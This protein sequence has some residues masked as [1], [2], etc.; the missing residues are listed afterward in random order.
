MAYK[1]ILKDDINEKINELEYVFDD[2]MSIKEIFAALI[3]RYCH[4]V[5]RFDQFNKLLG[6]GYE[7]RYW[8]TKGIEREA[9]KRAC[10]EAI[11][12]PTEEKF[13]EEGLEGKKFIDL[14][15]DYVIRNSKDCNTPCENIVREIIL[16]KVIYFY[17]DVITGLYSS[18]SDEIKNA[19]V[20]FKREVKDFMAYVF[21]ED[22]FCDME[23]TDDVKAEIIKFAEVLKD[24]R[25]EFI[26][27]YLLEETSSLLYDRH[28]LYMEE[29]AMNTNINVVTG[30]RF[31]DTEYDDEAAGESEENKDLSA[32]NEGNADAEKDPKAEAMELLERSRIILSDLLY[33]TDSTYTAFVELTYFGLYKLTDGNKEE[34]LKILEKDIEKTKKDLALEEKD[35]VIYLKEKAFKCVSEIKDTAFNKC[36][37]EVLETI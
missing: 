16:S 18:L 32:E 3:A 19:K 17:M 10:E 20:D 6:A 9:R 27:N 35:G 8:I 2:G 28:C 34:M 23:M 5:R 30:E 7:E 13:T 21:D 12:A 26:N 36:V 22:E 15:D 33:V 37:N 1:N 4:P 14:V 24:G 11:L 31:I 29:K 25:S